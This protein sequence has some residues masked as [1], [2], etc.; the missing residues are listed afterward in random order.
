MKTYQPGEPHT[1]H[2]Y[3]SFIAEVEGLSVFQ[4]TSDS[5]YFG[6]WNY[7]IFSSTG[8]PMLWDYAKHLKADPADPFDCQCMTWDY[9]PR[10]AYDKLCEFLVAHYKLSF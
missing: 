10:P 6:N 2:Q 3:T 9:Y 7:L 8:R 5:H 1:G 4:L